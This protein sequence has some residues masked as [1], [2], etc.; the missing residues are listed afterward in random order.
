MAVPKTMKAIHIP[1]SSIYS[2]TNPARAASLILDASFPMPVPSP[3]QSLI[4]IHATAISPFELTWEGAYGITSPRIPCFDIAGTIISSPPTS[5]FIPGDKVF[6]LLDYMA[7]GAMAE[8]AVSDPKFLAKIPP[9]AGFVQA[10]S[11]PRAAL[12]AWQ[13]IMV[14]GKGEV[15][16]GSKVLVTGATGAVGK[17]TLQV[18]RNV[19]GEKGKVVA[20]GGKGSE[21]LKELGA[22][23]VVDY[24]NGEWEDTVRAQG[25]IDWVL[26]CVGGETLGK[27]LRLVKDGGQVVTIGSPPP[28]FEDVKDWNVAKERGVKAL[29]FI[30][31][32]SGEQL[33][34]IGKLVSKGELKPSISIVVDGLTE[35]GVR[36]S[37][38]KAEKG[39]LAGSV[40]VKIL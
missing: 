14:R 11:L 7:Q 37:W 23:V 33:L 15:G 24:R 1:T 19:L 25:M 27:C 3:T 26:D 28:V 17:M 22:D 18:L 40:V 10:A 16:E 38:T 29:F 8:Y 20:I 35:Q 36:E 2:Y 30:V 5:G 12:T 6:G 34:E 4:R 32:E 13:A 21:T 31:E 39:G 9:E